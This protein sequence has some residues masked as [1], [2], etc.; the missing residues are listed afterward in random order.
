MSCARCAGA[1]WRNSGRR[2]EP[3]DA[4]ALGRFSIAWH[5]IGSSR[6]GLEALLDTI[7]QLQ[8]AAIPASVSRANCSR[9]ALPI[10]A[11]RC[12]TPLMAAGEVIW[13]GVEPLGERDGR[14]ALYLTDHLPR[15]RAPHIAAGR[16]EGANRS[17][18]RSDEAER[19]ERARDIESYLRATVP[20]SLRRP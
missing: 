19:S 20:A 11:R 9:R 8:G 3:V 12:S 17:T 5:G 6:R 2:I 18:K 13:T 14:I 7:E 15:L 4:D 16:R 10:T 1:R